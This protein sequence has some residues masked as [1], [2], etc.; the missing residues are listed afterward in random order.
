MFISLFLFQM[1][2]LSLRTTKIHNRPKSRTEKAPQ[3]AGENMLNEKKGQAAKAKEKENRRLFA[4]RKNR[5]RMK[6]NDF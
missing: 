2:R 4:N 1:H 3:G 5:R 6:R